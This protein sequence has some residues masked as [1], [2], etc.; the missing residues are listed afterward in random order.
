MHILA[1]HG[2]QRLYNRFQHFP[3]LYFWLIRKLPVI[4]IVIETHALEEA[5][6]TYIGMKINNSTVQTALHII[7][8]KKWILTG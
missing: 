2:L 8:T 1:Y 7:N 3:S 4:I 6:P 5:G